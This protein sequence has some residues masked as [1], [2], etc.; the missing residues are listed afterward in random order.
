MKKQITVLF[1]LIL[2]ICSFSAN[3]VWAYK[4]E[5]IF[6]KSFEASSGHTL[7]IENR[8]GN[9]NVQT[10][11]KNEVHIEVVVKVEMQSENKVNNLLS[12]ID[13]V[14]GQANKIISAKTT[15]PKNF[16]CNNCNMNI[17]YQ[18]MVPKGLH[19]II[20]HKYGNVKLPDI[21]GNTNLTVHYGNL[22]TGNHSGEKSIVEVYGNFD[23]GDYTGN[24]NNIDVKYGNINMKKLIGSSNL[25]NA[26][27][28]S[29]V[30]INQISKLKM[31]IKYSKLKI[32]T[33]EE[34][35]IESG[36]TNTTIG[37]TKKL[38]V[39]SKYE[40]YDI[41]EADEIDANFEYTNVS[42][43]KLAKSIKISEIKYGKLK[44]DYV[45]TDFELIK[46]DSKYTNF[47]ITFDPKT[48]YNINL[49]NNYG[50]ISVP[51]GNISRSEPSSN[52][53]QV[54]GTVG[55]GSAKGK[56]EITNKYANINL[57]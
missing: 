10:W 20:N 8:Y 32:N 24:L 26:K 23:A 6:K 29:I 21:S 31:N 54:T 16:N 50:N 46:A 53:I 12:Q 56:V 35:Y 27:Y 4:T 36:Y 22:N 39:T 51:S 5:K 49:Y 55:N 3:S 34:L 14:F 37:K 38:N 41:G 42:I 2:C 57:K 44:I 11:D 30:A 28:N 45:S 48:S 33:A 43:E 40:N 52:S 18:V 1:V 25:V 47:N 13:I 15:F 9:I 7:S 19:Y 17:D